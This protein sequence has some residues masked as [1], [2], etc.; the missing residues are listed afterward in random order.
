M[1]VGVHDDCEHVGDSEPQPEPEPGR[2][3]QSLQP[4][5]GKHKQKA[6]SQA[7]TSRAKRPRPYDEISDEDGGEIEE[8]TRSDSRPK[9]IARLGP[10]ITTPLPE[11]TAEGQST[12]IEELAE[13]ARS[14]K[15]MQGIL[16]NLTTAV[17]AKS[18]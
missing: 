3:R 13:L 15:K 2:Q 18:T 8:T 6:G 9:K 12:T 7:T 1:K 11:P 17:N 5:K 16:T 14:M 10:E 4:G